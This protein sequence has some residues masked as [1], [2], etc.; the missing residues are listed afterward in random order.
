MEGEILDVV[1]LKIGGKK[2]YFRRLKGKTPEPSDER[3][4]EIPRRKG[5]KL[6]KRVMVR[7]LPRRQ[8]VEFTLNGVGK[9]RAVFRLDSHTPLEHVARW[10]WYFP[11]TESGGQYLSL[12]TKHLHGRLEEIIAEETARS[13]EGIWTDRAIAAVQTTNPADIILPGKIYEV[14]SLEILPPT[15]LVLDSADEQ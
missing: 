7:H 5:A 8:E 13:D 2:H 15:K 1:A 14:A 10:F 11:K 12:V 4:V 6:R 9:M 3:W